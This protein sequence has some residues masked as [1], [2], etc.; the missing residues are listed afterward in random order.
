LR[1]RAFGSIARL[2]SLSLASLFLSGCYVLK[3]GLE[4]NNLINSRRPLAAVIAD[5]STDAKT[6]EKLSY[7]V[8]VMDYAV[9]Q[10]LNTGGAYQHFVTLD[11]PVVSWIV[12]AAHADRLKSVTWWFPIVGRVPYLGFFERKERDAKAEELRAAGYDVARGGVGAFSSLG[13]FEDPIYSS[14][15]NRD[16]TDL[17]HLLFHEL[18]HRT[19][20]SPGSVE[21][22]ENLA[23]FVADELT[24]LYLEKKAM[25]NEL[26][27]HRA[28]RADRELLRVWLRDLRAAL[29]ALYSGPK[30]GD[31]PAILTEKKAV[32]DHFTGAARPKF[33]VE[34]LVEGRDWNNAS[35]LGA[36][37]YS[38]DTVRF[39]RAFS[40]VSGKAG[41]TGSITV[42]RF[43]ELFREE[44]NENDDDGFKALDSMAAP[45]SA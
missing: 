34:D 2:I 15:L 36:S 4:Q 39:E 38:P 42:G 1:S 7:A 26:S 28:R 22:N 37:L 44:L 16:D 12:Q 31:R 33:A 30:K 5:P 35:V 24:K 25:T 11:R 19:F 13:W 20:W 3:L 10:G 9:S 43:L 14:M 41:G 29:D 8:E 40:C 45:C 18:T 27:T 32:F 6:R 21:F 23:E 17:A